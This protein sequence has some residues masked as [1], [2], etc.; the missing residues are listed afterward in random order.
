MSTAFYIYPRKVAENLYILALWDGTS[1]LVLG[2][3]EDDDA[4]ISIINP[5]DY[6]YFINGDSFMSISGF[7]ITTAAV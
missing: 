3:N 5:T 6:L 2:A 4:N 7:H 1:N